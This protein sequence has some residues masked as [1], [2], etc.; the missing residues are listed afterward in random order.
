MT[1]HEKG[2]ASAGPFPFNVT[3]NRDGGG[4]GNA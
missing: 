2:P 3:L 4:G 1:D